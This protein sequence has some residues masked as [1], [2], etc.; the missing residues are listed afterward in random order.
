M[1]VLLENFAEASRAEDEAD[2]VEAESANL[3][4]VL[5]YEKVNPSLLVDT[6][7]FCG[8]QETIED[9]KNRESL[10]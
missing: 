3:A 10:E 6:G 5:R 4:L 7:L 1:A 2:L 9:Q 8:S